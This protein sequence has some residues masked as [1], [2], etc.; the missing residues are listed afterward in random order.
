MSAEVTCGACRSR[1]L[2]TPS[3]VSV[4]SFVEWIL[5][6]A[7]LSNLEI[8]K[9]SKFGQIATNFPILFSDAQK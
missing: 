1:W 8:V 6:S 7:K 3:T 5:I 2:N 4:L 9:F